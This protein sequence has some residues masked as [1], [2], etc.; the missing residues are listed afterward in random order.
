[1]YFNTTD[2]EIKAGDRIIGRV[3]AIGRDAGTTYLKNTRTNKEYKHKFVNQTALLGATNAEWVTECQTGYDPEDGLYG[4]YTAHYN[5]WRFE[6]AKYL[7]S[8]T[9]S[10]KN[11]KIFPLPFPP[12]FMSLN[13]PQRLTIS[14]QQTKSST[15]PA[16]TRPSTHTSTAPKSPRPSTWVRASSKSRTPG[17]RASTPAFSPAAR[18]RAEGCEHGT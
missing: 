1:M 2:G 16:R 4:S 17:R 5:P 9:F 14:H 13:H 10:K 15:S 11:K 7:T 8:G 12:P 18:E 3:E 6:N